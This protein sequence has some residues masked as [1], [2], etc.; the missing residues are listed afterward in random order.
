MK[1]CSPKNPV[2][3]RHKSTYI[4][5]VTEAIEFEQR[6]VQNNDPVEGGVAY[7]IPVLVVTKKQNNFPETAIQS[8]QEGPDEDMDLDLGEDNESTAASSFG[9]STGVNGSDATLE[10]DELD[11]ERRQRSKEV[12]VKIAIIA[13]EPAIPVDKATALTKSSKPPPGHNP[14]KPSLVIPSLNQSNSSRHALPLPR[15]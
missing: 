7:T 3:T 6:R 2:A 4:D 12:L 13:E 11:P 8:H 1:G 15:R 5:M 10:G 14:L 9:P